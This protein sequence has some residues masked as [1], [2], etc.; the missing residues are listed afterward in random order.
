MQKLIAFRKGPNYMDD[1]DDEL[2]ERL[3]KMENE[4]EDL[5]SEIIPRLEKIE[6]EQ[7]QLDTGMNTI[8]NT[9]DEQ[10]KQTPHIGSV[11]SLYTRIQELEEQIAQMRESL[12]DVVEESS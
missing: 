5:N 3:E 11:E 1:E 9:M 4:F 8:L 6:D 2:E 12:E 10:G 7:S